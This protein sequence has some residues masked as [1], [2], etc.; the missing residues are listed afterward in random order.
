MAS[1]TNPEDEALLKESASWPLD[2]RISHSNWRVRSA[3]FDFVVDQTGA[4]A[5]TRDVLE[6]N[7]GLDASTCLELLASSVGDQNANVMD[8]ALDAFFA[9]LDALG[10]ILV[11]VEGRETFDESFT[12][13]AQVTMKHL[14]TKC[15]KASK[16]TT[17]VKSMGVCGALVE[18]DQ[19]MAV[20]QGLV[21][22]GFSHKV[23]KAVAAALE[24]ALE[25]IR[26]FYG[27]GE[28]DQRRM[29][30]EAKELLGGIAAAKL[31]AHRDAA[32][33]SR[34]KDVVV[35]L[36]RTS[37]RVECMV[38]TKLLDK[39]PDAMQKEVLSD[40]DHGDASPGESN[41]KMYTKSVQ[42]RL[43]ELAAAHVAGGADAPGHG[44]GPGA[45]GYA[46]GDVEMMDVD[47]DVDDGREADQDPY[48]F[49]EPANIMPSLQKA[50]I[51]V[52]PDADAV[53]FWD[54]FGSKKWNVR[55]SALE[56]VR[57][58]ASKA[59][60]LDPAERDSYASLVREFKVIL[61]KD[62]NIHCAATAA[63]ASE[64]MAKAL[65]SDF[66]GNAKLI[67]PDLLGRFKEKNPVMS[68]AAESCLQS[69]ATYCYSL[70]DVSDDIAAALSV[71]N[72]KVLG[73]TL[74][75]L[76]SL[77]ELEAGRAVALCKDSLAAAVKLLSD[78]DSNVR[79]EAQAAV[80]AFA[81]AMGGFAAV[82]THLNGVDDKKRGAIEK[83]CETASAAGGA[84]GQ[85]KCAMKTPAAKSRPGSSR[86]PGSSRP[87]PGRKAAARPAAAPARATS[88]AVTK[89]AV[90][91]TAVTKTAVT[92]TGPAA[93]FVENPVSKEEAE[94]ILARTFG[95][96]MVENLKSSLWQERVEAMSQ[97]AERAGE[98]FHGSHERED[99]KRLLLA[100]AHLPGWTDR[101]FQVVN[102]LFEMG[103]KAAELSP[104]GDFGPPHASCIVQGAVEKIHELKHR[105][106]ASTALTAA[107]Q[108]VGPKYVVSLVHQRAA[109]HKNPK[110][111]AE[112]LA[113][114]RNTIDQFGYNNI[115]SKG[116]VVAWMTDDLGST[117]PNVK[118]KALALLGE[119][120]SQVGSGPFQ[121]L[122]DSL[123]SK[124]PALATSMQEAF[125]K[126]PMDASYEPTL[127][128]KSGEVH[129]GQGPRGDD[130][131]P[132]SD[133]KGEFKEDADPSDEPDAS[134]PI[135]QELVERVDVSR[136]LG[137]PLVAQLM[138]TN[139]KER[140]AAVESVEE[141]IASAKHITADVPVEFL[142]ALRKRFGDSNRNLAARSLSLVGMLATAVGPDFDLIA[143]SILLGPAVEN[144]ADMKRQVRDAVVGML[145]AWG[146]SC[147]CDRLFPAIID[148]VSNPKGAS[149]G[150][151][152][153][154]KWMVDHYEP[155]PRCRDSAL[156]AAAAGAKDKAAPVRSMASQLEKLVE[157]QGVGRVAVG[158][159]SKTATGATPAQ[160][161]RLEQ[162]GGPT[163]TPAAKV[164][165]KSAANS[166]VKSASRSTGKNLGSFRPE[167]RAGARHMRADDMVL[168]MGQG[169]GTRSR[170]FRPRPGCFEAPTPGDRER[171]RE[172]L[173][174]VASTMLAAK[175]FSGDFQDHID[176]L[177]ALE[178]GVPDRMNELLTSLDL[179]LQWIVLVLCEQNT[180][181]SLRALDLLRVV[182]EHLADDGYRLSDM[183]ASILLPAIIEKI[184]QN[185]DHM[186]SAYRTIL[187]ASASVYNPAKVV[188][189]IILGLA[190]RNSRSK[191]ECCAA[192]SDIVQQTGGRCMTSAKNKP[193]VALS[194]LV[195][196][197]DPA[198]RSAAMG[199]LESI[200][201]S[202]DEAMFTDMLMKAK[203]GDR[204]AVEGKL[205]P[206]KAKGA[207]VGA[208][209]IDATT[210]TGVLRE[211]PY[212]SRQSYLES[213]QKSYPE[214]MHVDPVHVEPMPVQAAG[215]HA[216]GVQRT[217]DLSSGLPGPREPPYSS[218]GLAT[219]VSH[220]VG[221]SNQAAA[222][223]TAGV[224]TPVPVQLKSTPSKSIDVEGSTIPIPQLK[225]DE[226]E[227]EQR[228][229]RNIELMYSANLTQ[230]VDATKHV[231]SDIMMVTAK[232][233]P[234]PSNRVKA[235]LSNTADK[236]VLAV[237]AQLEVIFADAVRQ[238]AEG[239]E[240]FVPPSSRG[241]K[242][243]LNALLQGLGVEDLAMGIPQGTLR[244][245]ISLLLCSLVDEH[246]L[247]CFEQG[248]TLVRAVNVLIAKM[249]DAANKNYAFAALLHLLRSPP[250][251]SLGQDAVPK[252]NDLVVKCLIKLTKGLDSTDVNIDIS[253]ILLCL[254][255]YFM[256]LGVEEI[257][258]RSAAEDKPLRMVKTILHQI[259]KLVG[260]N[261]YQY[262]SSIPGRHAQPQP[263]IFRYIDINLKMLKEMNQ[264]PTDDGAGGV[265]GVGGA[266]PVFGAVAA[267][268]TAHHA[269]SYHNDDEEV[270]V[271]LKDVLSRVTSKDPSVKDVSM[272]ELLDLKRKHP[273][274][275]ERYLNAT[276][277]RFRKYIEDGLLE[278]AGGGH[279]APSGGSVAASD[280][281]LGGGG[282]P[283]SSS[284]SIPSFDNL[285]ERLDRL[286]QRM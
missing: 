122:M 76:T 223:S 70:K 192:M 241:C 180:Q 39:L 33:R 74:R 188:D 265:G 97:I 133:T 178:E 262:T 49:A 98:L 151:V 238:V 268:G 11:F 67:C 207:A 175:M 183:E 143:H 162:S 250:S 230:A 4:H 42:K 1:T 3:A 284:S 110:V 86:D 186:R 235:V 141:L 191:V 229:E 264:L 251:K 179:I 285:A 38:R 62:A 139:W 209:P 138:S 114:M 94:E 176:A 237:C 65:R 225:Y 40:A 6:H 198:L 27:T 263:I 55:K 276:Q 154:L 159:P 90:T 93:A 104:G 160:M 234:P 13:T 30:N 161:K 23:P 171:L 26:G 155:N 99:V 106:Q 272:R 48:E 273:Q 245:A 9:Y 174:P 220:S 190:T 18:V 270:R 227:L 201:E 22:G 31:Y 156:K 228:W 168:S 269:G 20:V 202:V 129:R 172:L 37:K 59:V 205:K 108:R 145:D 258:R 243:A 165:P 144:L 61:A 199:A 146:H 53:P 29:E 240:N 170:Q 244:T 117:D 82:K 113:W 91:K 112:S 88:T 166:T 283:S 63:M 254:H 242:F 17:L 81:V 66:A 116:S 107:C 137:E 217:L 271:K 246:G 7:V 210:E 177:N 28:Y 195:T 95:P 127:A 36:M 169:K 124:K 215:A 125:A 216:D 101:N 54:C 121:S 267:T 103:T 128:V 123:Q 153:A 185:Q 275:V 44:E 266:G 214:P 211:D 115:D 200:R 274:M 279:E 222:T 150:K 206:S 282:A 281:R 248:P 80:V 78:A 236:F 52:D 232:D 212:R 164:A 41:E 184:G 25:I 79:Q 134:A 249:L 8:R 105:E 16:R 226:R 135:Q 158:K 15:L 32:V 120:H 204:Q 219:P 252:F 51:K 157:V 92:K 233:G 72:P 45:G 277:D 239:G 68:K 231:C 69:F 286:R 253:F 173:A 193:V 259:C 247:L 100:L 109:W 24:A 130:A 197:R 58:A 163:R 89:T 126:K 260:Y 64:A 196:E 213:H 280:V 19:G 34:V 181:S 10:T 224:H 5:A 182:L 73:E 2:R 189:M 142:G 47:V 12:R 194:Q 278:M 102:K 255:D 46:D 203:D 218:S 118:S 187:V 56:M 43:R 131:F 75:Y 111:L 256:F 21:E 148:A 35:A 96:G 87:A 119:C 136:S 50:K 257:R 208:I 149:E 14:S 71:K 152:M 140:N 77:V 261:V 84:A 60:R 85:M 57:D 83:A 167:A 132:D 221:A 147:G